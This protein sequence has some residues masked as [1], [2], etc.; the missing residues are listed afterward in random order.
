MG[1][2]HARVNFYSPEDAIDAYYLLQGFQIYEGCC[3]LDIYFAGESI[4]RCKS[5]IRWYKLGYRPP[6]T[7]LIPCQPPNG[8]Y[9]DPSRKYSKKRLTSYRKTD[10]IYHEHDRKF[11]IE[12]KIERRIK[13]MRIWK[14]MSKS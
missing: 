14:Q 4:C 6:R 9:N 3:E 7:P 11:I 13:K 8:D 5:Y 12:D 10:S 1:D 2:V